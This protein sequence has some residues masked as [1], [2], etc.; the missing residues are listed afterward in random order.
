MNAE[1]IEFTR[2]NNNASGNPRLVCHF[3]NL[4]T[5]AER[6]ETSIGNMYALAISKAKKIRGRKYHTRGYGGGIVFT[7][8]DTP[9]ELTERINKLKGE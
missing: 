7:T 8:Y 6:K 9:Q 3:I 2:V 5:D 1:T 4:L